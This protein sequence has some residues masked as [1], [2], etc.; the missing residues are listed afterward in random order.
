MFAQLRV[1]SDFAK[2]KFRLLPWKS[3]QTILGWK[4]PPPKKKTQ[5]QALGSEWLVEMWKVLG[6]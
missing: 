4:T 2:T 3:V 6:N 1:H 5:N